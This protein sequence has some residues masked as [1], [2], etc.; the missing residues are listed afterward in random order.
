MIRSL[1]KDFVSLLSGRIEGR[2]V[3]DFEMKKRAEDSYC[4]HEKLLDIQDLTEKRDYVEFR[5]F[6]TDHHW[7][8]F[9][10]TT[11]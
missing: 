4:E 9:L 10:F 6:L 8:Q 2:L 1:Y 11:R 3:P 7:A 5:E